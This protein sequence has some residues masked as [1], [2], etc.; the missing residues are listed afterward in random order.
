METTPVS[1][2]KKDPQAVRSHRARLMKYAATAFT[3][4]DMELARPAS[5]A[6]QSRAHIDE[7]LD[8]VPE[9]GL[10]LLSMSK[11]SGSTKPGKQVG[12]KGKMREDIEE[13]DEDDDN[14]FFGTDNA[15][16]DDEESDHMDIDDEG[17]ENGGVSSKRRRENDLT[18]V[19]EDDA[20]VAKRKPFMSDY[21][22]TREA[23]IARNQALLKSLG[24]EP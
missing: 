2:V 15:T 3:K 21:E 16:D 14:A 13:T 5:G 10:P 9:D 17:H 4:E 18:D 12:R 7:A 6:I 22:K 24:L 19:D 8:C 20:P 11:G 1:F 23:N